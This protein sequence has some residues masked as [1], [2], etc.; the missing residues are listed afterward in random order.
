MTQAKTIILNVHGGVV[1][2]IM[3]DNEVRVI[4]VDWDNA[5]DNDGLPMIGDYT[6]IE[7]M[8]DDC[9]VARALRAADISLTT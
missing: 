9:D 7:P 3:G 4:V 8:P 5:E 1:Q 2:D 6:E